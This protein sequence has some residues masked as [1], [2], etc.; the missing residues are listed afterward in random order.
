MLQ[1]MMH[2]SW[3]EGMLS[4]PTRW[5]SFKACKAQN[6]CKPACHV[7]GKAAARRVAA[8]MYHDCRQAPLVS[9]APCSPCQLH[10]TGF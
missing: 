2:K 9:H 1:V 10:K 8:H 5:R 6:C 7:S 4:R 3:S